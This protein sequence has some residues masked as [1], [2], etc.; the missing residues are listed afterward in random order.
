M[1]KLCVVTCERT[2]VKVFELIKSL[3]LQRKFKNLS[4][5]VPV[6]KSL[7]SVKSDFQAFLTPYAFHFVRK[8]LGQSDNVQI[9][10]K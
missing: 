1:E 2:L 8:Q 10:D 7:N 5:K 4:S 3:S 6:V 9:K